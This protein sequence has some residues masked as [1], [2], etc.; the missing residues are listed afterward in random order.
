MA[1]RPDPQRGTVSRGR[2]YGLGRQGNGGSYRQGGGVGRPLLFLGILGI[3]VLLLIVPLFGLLGGAVGS[4]A[5]GLA[6]SNPAALRWPFVADL[7]KGQ[8][9]DRIDRPAG[10]DP[11][12]VRFQVRTGASAEDV[13]RDLAQQGIV[14][15]AL[16]FQYLVV[17][18]GV[19]GEIQAGTYVLARNMTPAEVLARLQQPPEQTVTIALREGLRIEQITA[20][21]ATL[22]LQTDLSRFYELATK[23]PQQ[24]R[25]QYD[26]LKTLPQGRSLEGYLGS[27]T[28]EVNV[29]ITAEDLLKRLLAQW[30]EQVSSAPI[31]QAAVRGKNFYEVL[32]LASIVEKEATLAS[33]RR[34]IAGVYANRI[35]RGM[36][37]NADP[38]VFYAWD[39][40]QLRQLRLADWPKYAF[41]RPIGKPL[42]EVEL[43]AELTG[44]QTYRNRGL[45]PGPICTPS[46]ASIQAALNPDQRNGYL[47][48]VAIRDGSRR[49]AF[50]RTLQEHQANLNRYGY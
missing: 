47:Y 42:R 36:L 48:F 12:P 24:L 40:L 4:A 39:T 49:H 6:E 37:L 13:A 33:E 34:L 43:P 22:G 14:A 38:T 2:V 19:G 50:A 30:H 23:P 31:R 8:L 5:R 26:A 10:T 18:R 3:A 11:T 25:A 20:Y 35:D 21:L 41:W 44:Y 27:G 46:V 28:Y 15:D 16:A 1:R 7:V 17:T 9:G 32:T 29:E 45:I